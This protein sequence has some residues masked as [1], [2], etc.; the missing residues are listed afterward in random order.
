MERKTTFDENIQTVG[1]DIQIF[2]ENVN[3]SR[4]YVYSFLMVNASSDGNI[5]LFDGT[6]KHK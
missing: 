2:N 5:Q 6:V 3:F 1:E 4:K